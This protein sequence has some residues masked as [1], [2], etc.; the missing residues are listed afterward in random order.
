MTFSP[1]LE[2]RFEKLLNSYPP[3]RQRSAV[4]PMLLYGQD[5]VG[6]V[7][8][9]LV[10]EVARRCGVSTLQVDE[11]IGYYSMLHKKPLGRYHV[12]VCTNIACQAVGGEELYEHASRTLGLGNKQVSSD[13]LISLEE[14]ECMGACSWAPAIQVN[15]DFFHQVTPER[16]DQLMDA[17]R[18]GS[19]G[20]QAS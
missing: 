2:A 11:V 10:E 1:E 13:G 15:Y 8:R 18:D 6:S 12:Q 4:V 20:R 14:V 16:F 7:T 17:L 3:G 19:Y 5:E 9:E